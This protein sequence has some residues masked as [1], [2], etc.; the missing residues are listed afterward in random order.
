MLSQPEER[1]NGRFDV[2][3]AEDSQNSGLIKISSMDT[4]NDANM[5]RL[6][7]KQEVQRSTVKKDLTIIGK[8]KYETLRD[9]V[10]LLVAPAL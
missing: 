8:I 10:S 3:D 2:P 1:V 4:E 7:S 5:S 6:R 9:N